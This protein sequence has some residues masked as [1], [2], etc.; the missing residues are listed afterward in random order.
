MAKT[1]DSSTSEGV[2]FAN[3]VQHAENGDSSAFERT[4]SRGSIMLSP[5]LFE[6]LYLNPKPQVAGNL[7][8]IIGNPTPIAITGF[9]MALTP[10]SFSLM[11][12]RGAGNNGIAH[13]GAYIFF[14]GILLL[15]G[16]LLECIIGNTFSSVVFMSFACFYLTLATTLQPFYNAYAAYSPNPDD[17][18]A[19]LTSEGFNASFGFF[20]VCFNLLCFFYL[21][22]SFRTNFVLVYILFTVV[23]GVGLI[24]AAY[25]YLAMQETVL[26]GKFQIGG[27]A[28]L[29]AACLGGWY[30]LFSL[31]LE[32]VDFP[33]RLPVGDLSSHVPGLSQLQKKSD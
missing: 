2:N 31:L 28:V 21:I 20:I 4:R 23:I 25:W 11:G 1:S 6:K 12:W 32:S 19:G 8:S 17:P 14:G 18:T 3:D 24:N 15:V 9:V 26:A 33:L 5:E 10:L 16:G 27:G 13:I 29:F 7:R 22:C 30:L